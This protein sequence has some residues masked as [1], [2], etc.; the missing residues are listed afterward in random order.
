MVELMH[1]GNIANYPTGAVTQFDHEKVATILESI[2]Q[3][4]T[5]TK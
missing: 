4:F 1:S 5:F 3:T 2:A